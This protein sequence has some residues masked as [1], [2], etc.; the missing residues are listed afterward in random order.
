MKHLES[1]EEGT[2]RAR[3]TMNEAIGDMMDP[4]L[5][6]ENVDCAEEGVHYHPDFHF[7]DP[8]DLSNTKHE[9]RKFMPIELYDGQVLE[10]MTRNLNEELTLLC[11]LSK[12][13]TLRMKKSFLSFSLSKDGQVPGKV[14]S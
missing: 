12:Q 11:L 3:D 2:E 13:D 5:A 6:Q 4:A 8:G 1:V 9:K 10:T 14:L 7:K